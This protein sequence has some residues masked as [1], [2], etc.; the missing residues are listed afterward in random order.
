MRSSDAVTLRNRLSTCRV[1]P[2]V[3]VSSLSAMWSTHIDSS[4]S[5]AQQFHCTATYYGVASTHQAVS[6]Q[7]P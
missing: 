2:L 4:S 3:P 7:V 6:G 1:N 5:S